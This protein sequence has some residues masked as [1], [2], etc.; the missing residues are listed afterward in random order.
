MKKFL[1][2]INKNLELNYFDKYKKADYNTNTKYYIIT[3]IRMYI[4]I[5]I[6]TIYFITRRQNN[7]SPK[8]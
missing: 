2:R 8:Y 3:W 4:K 1:N 5:S 7:N 6:F